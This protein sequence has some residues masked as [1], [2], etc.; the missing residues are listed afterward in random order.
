MGMLNHVVFQQFHF[1]KSRDVN[2]SKRFITEFF[3]RAMGSRD[4]Y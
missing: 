1:S 4:I 2:K 3:L